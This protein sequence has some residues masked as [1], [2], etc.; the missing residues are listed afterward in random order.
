M[1]DNEVFPKPGTDTNKRAP[2]KINGRLHALPQAFIDKHLAV[3]TAWD[4]SKRPD[5]P[6]AE[7]FPDEP[8]LAN[9]VL[10]TVSDRKETVVRS[11]TGRSML[12]MRAYADALSAAESG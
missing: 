12:D 1:A 9:V 4:W 5:M 6:L 3:L 10:E 7:V 8:A 2:R 11:M